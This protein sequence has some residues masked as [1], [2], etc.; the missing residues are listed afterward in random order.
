MGLAQ[1]EQRNGDHAEQ[2]SLLSPEELE[3]RRFRA[4]AAARTPSSQ[5][6]RFVSRIALKAMLFKTS[7]PSVGEQVMNRG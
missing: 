1:K 6:T 5:T 4:P 3:A 2:L 7:F